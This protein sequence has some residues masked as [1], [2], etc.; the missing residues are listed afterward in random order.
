MA[1][2]L[3]VSYYT[4]LCDLTNLVNLARLLSIIINLVCSTPFPKCEIV[5]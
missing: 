3:K 5:H 1:F 2:L 4:N